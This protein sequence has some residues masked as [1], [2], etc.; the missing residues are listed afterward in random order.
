MKTLVIHIQDT[1]TD[2][3]KPIYDLT[4]KVTVVRTNLSAKVMNDLIEEHDRIIMLGHGSDNGLFGDAGGMIIGAENVP[5]LANKDNSIFIWCHASDFVARWGLRGFSTGM[6]ISEVGEALF[7][8]VGKQLSRAIL[9][10]DVE[11]SNDEF[12]W[13][14]G[15]NIDLNDPKEL[16]TAV[17]SEYDLQTEVCNY[18]RNLLVAM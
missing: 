8:N 14:V 2:F 12:A 6:F 18:N 5:A 3:L 13:I 16:L 10:E 11:A 1:S 9:L 15:Q 4:A 17:K 7:C